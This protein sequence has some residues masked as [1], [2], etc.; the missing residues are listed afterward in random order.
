[1][2]NYNCSMLGKEIFSHAFMIK[3]VCTVGRPYVHYGCQYYY[4][5]LNSWGVTGGNQHQ[6][7][8]TNELAMEGGTDGRMKV[9]MGFAVPPYIY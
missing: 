6:K 9:K 4:C 2:S 3:F 8:S 5:M 1:M 7:R